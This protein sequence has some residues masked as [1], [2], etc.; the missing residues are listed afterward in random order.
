LEAKARN[1]LNDAEVQA[2]KEAAEHWCRLATDH[3]TCNG[4][5]PWKY[6]LIPHDVIAENMT[7][8]GLVAGFS[9]RSPSE[10]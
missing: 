2:K 6:L 5:K 7:F 3:T 8:A 9:A 1:D 4:G 10:A